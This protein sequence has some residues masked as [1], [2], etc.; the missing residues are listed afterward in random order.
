MLWGIGM[1]FGVMLLIGIVAQVTKRRH[2]AYD[3]RQSTTDFP[4]EE[5]AKYRD[6]PWTLPP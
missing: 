6:S 1:G 4:V 5:Q 3:P 2:P